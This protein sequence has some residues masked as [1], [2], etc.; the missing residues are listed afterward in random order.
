MQRAPQPGVTE[1]LEGGGS[2]CTR[3]NSRVR[4]IS[5]AMHLHQR[6]KVPQTP[7]QAAPHVPGG[8]CF[9]GGEKSGFLAPLNLPEVRAKS[10]QCLLLGPPNSTPKALRGVRC[11]VRC[12]VRCGIRCGDQCGCLLDPLLQ[13]PY[14]S[15]WHGTGQAALSYLSGPLIYWAAEINLGSVLLWTLPSQAP[16]PWRP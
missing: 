15:W 12:R 1:R 5:R 8:G 16:S 11:W 14:Q 10:A 2:S 4:R 6:H 9:Q 13:N 7:S 3:I